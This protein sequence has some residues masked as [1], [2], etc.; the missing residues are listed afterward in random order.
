M[1]TYEYHCTSCGYRFDEFLAM[2]DRGKPEKRACTQCGEQKIKQ[3]FFTPPV[4]G[5][6]SSL[7]PT[8]EFKEVLNRMKNNGMVPPKY[9]DNLDRAA[10]RDGRSYKTQ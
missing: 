5:T 3:G 6:D 9:H 2:K 7:K 10:N 8:P 4:G 1:P